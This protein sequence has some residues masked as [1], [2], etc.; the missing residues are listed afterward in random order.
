MPLE[1]CPRAQSGECK[2]RGSANEAKLARKQTERA[3]IFKDYQQV[4]YA[5]FTKEPVGEETRARCDGGTYLYVDADMLYE[6]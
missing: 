1:T 5:L 3:A 2:W 6:A 4:W